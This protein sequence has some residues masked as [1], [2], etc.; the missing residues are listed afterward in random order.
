MQML[1]KLRRWEC[2]WLALD[3]LLEASD[4]A[5][6]HCRLE[7]HTRGMLGARE[8]ALLKPT[9]YLINVGTG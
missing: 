8:L 3:T 7:E 4:F 9:A 5:S 2:R 6:L 1:C